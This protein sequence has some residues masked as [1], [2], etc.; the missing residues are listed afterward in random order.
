[1]HLE[2]KSG[3][4][5]DDRIDLELSPS[6]LEKLIRLTEEKALEAPTYFEQ[7]VWRDLT[8][9]LQECLSLLT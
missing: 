9:K 5:F 2:E 7:D 4:A 6:N 3:C 8:D 1:M